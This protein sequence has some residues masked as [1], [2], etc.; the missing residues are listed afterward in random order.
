MEEKHILFRKLSKTFTEGFLLRFTE[1]TR[2]KELLDS[3]EA[4]RYLCPFDLV[5][6]S[7]TGLKILKKNQRCQCNILKNWRNTA[8][9]YNLK[10]EGN[11]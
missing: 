1:E 4:H 8:F 2:T 5:L 7:D 10:I 9:S 6:G 3:L 11:I